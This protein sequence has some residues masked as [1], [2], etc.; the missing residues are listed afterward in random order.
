MDTSTY[1]LKI[2]SMDINLFKALVKKMGWIAL[3]EKSGIGKGLE[4][5]KEG[6]VYSAKD[7]QDLVKQILGNG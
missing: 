5:I 7:S 4:D 1:I 2:P 6:R 3:E